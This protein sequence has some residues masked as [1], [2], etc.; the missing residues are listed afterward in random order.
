MNKLAKLT[1]AAAAL[2]VVAS[3][4][5]R[6]GSHPKVQSSYFGCASNALGRVPLVLIRPY[7]HCEAVVFA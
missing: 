1:L 4:V 5:A 3:V 7:V 2:V 6:P